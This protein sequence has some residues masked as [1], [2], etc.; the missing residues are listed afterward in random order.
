MAR[1]ALTPTTLPRLPDMTP[2]ANA[3]DVTFVASDVVDGNSV[4][5]TGKEMLIARNDDIGAVTITIAGIDDAIG[6]AGSITAYSVG[7][8]ETAVFDL[9][10]PAF[11]TA[12]N[13][14]IDAS[15]ADLMLGVAIVASMP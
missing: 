2:T 7:A 12:G 11:S 14:N 6:R 5:W 4:P 3:A 10:H 9:S 13:V 15:D 8:G 1:T